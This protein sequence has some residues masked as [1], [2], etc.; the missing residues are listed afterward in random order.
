TRAADVVRLRNAIAEFHGT[1]TTRPVVIFIPAPL[2]EAMALRSAEKK[3]DLPANVIS[4]P[5]PGLG[6]ECIG[7][8]TTVSQARKA[9]QS[10]VGGNANRMFRVP[11]WADSYWTV[12][13]YSDDRVECYESRLRP[14]K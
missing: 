8:V 12:N 3:F 13:I 4:F 5:C 10:L 6:P 2:K 7:H 1:N 9:L 11:T 14:E